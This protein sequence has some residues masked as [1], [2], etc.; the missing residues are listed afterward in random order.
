MW[1]MRD[2][3]SEV[4]TISNKLSNSVLTMATS[5]LLAAGVPQAKLDAKVGVGLGLRASSAE[6]HAGWAVRHRGTPVCSRL[7][8]F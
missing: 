5:E 3:L 1:Q 2:F 8:P 7:M 6:M 4:V